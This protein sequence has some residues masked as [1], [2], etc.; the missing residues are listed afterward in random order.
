MP[1][2]SGS[3]TRFLTR[4]FDKVDPM[5]SELAPP[6]RAPKKSMRKPSP[7][8]A[9]GRSTGRLAAVQAIYFIVQSDAVVDDVLRDFVSGR[10]GRAAIAENPDTGQ[11]IYV[12]LAEA[13]SGLLVDIVRCWQDRREDIE[14]L[15]TQSLSVGWPA[16]RLELLAKCVLSAGTA[17]LLSR[18]DVP[19]R[20]TISEFVDIAKAFYAGPETGMVNAVLDR[21]ARAIDRLEP[22]NTDG[23]PSP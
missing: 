4:F 22:K 8:R 2:G 13:D 12:D 15:I 23:D 21:V 1:S 16:E 14:R 11:E 20:V 19:A 3:L 6:S 10:V 5:P 17:E 7:D 9:V 18:P